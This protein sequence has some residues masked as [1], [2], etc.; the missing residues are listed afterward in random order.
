[1]VVIYGLERLAFAQLLAG[2]WAAL[3]GSV[4][5][6]LTLARGV[7]QP[8]L[9]AAPLAWLALLAALTGTGEYD[10]HLAQLD[11]VVAT[12]PLGVLTD[13]VY[14]L[15]RWAKATRAS[16]DGDAAAALHH[17]GAMRLP[18]LRRMTAVDRI[19]AAVRAG[20]PARAL[21][22]VDE[23][24]VFAAATGRPWALAAVDLGRAVTA[25]PARAAELFEGALG[26]YG[27][28]S[29]PYDQA[30]TRLAY[31]EFL[32]RTNRRVDARTQLRSAWETFTDLDAQ[33]LVVRAGEQLR[34]SGETARKRDPSTLRQLT[35]MEARIAHLVSTGLSNKDVAAQCWVSPRTVAFHLRNVFAKVGVSSRGQLAQLDLG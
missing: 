5:E 21:A 33:P 13:P 11:A 26:H 19:G 25:D 15:T 6:A 27:H 22:W 14:D 10:Q 8:T 29:R 7:G 34:A 4:D 2:E 16:A 32:R 35:S 20:E 18:A 28:A 31:G 17:L 12:Y 24:A 23:L 1:M 9:T 3:R 30:R